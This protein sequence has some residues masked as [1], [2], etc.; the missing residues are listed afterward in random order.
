MATLPTAEQTA[1][2]I[3]AI[4]VG[5]FKCRPGFVLRLNNFMAIWHGRGLHAEDFKPGMEYAA[6]QEWIEVRE[7]GGSFRLTEAGFAEA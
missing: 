6:Q 4:F 2:E 1:R 7:D 5:H 3:L